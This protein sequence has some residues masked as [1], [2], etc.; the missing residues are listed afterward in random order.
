MR[1]E[2][3]FLVWP[4]LCVAVPMPGAVILYYYLLNFD[5]YS[6]FAKYVLYV[7]PFSLA[8]W[9]ALAL[10][11]IRRRRT[12][13]ALLTFLC[14]CFALPLFLYPLYTLSLFESN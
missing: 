2:N 9:L 11:G 7:A 6:A 1:L 8:F 5:S 14:V 13:L 10:F 3:T 12:F 4:L